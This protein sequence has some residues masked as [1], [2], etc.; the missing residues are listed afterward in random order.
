MRRHNR[1]MKKIHQKKPHRISASIWQKSARP[2]ITLVKFKKR[3][4]ALGKTAGWTNCPEC[5]GRLNL[6]LVDP[7]NR[8]RMWCST[9][10]CTELM[11]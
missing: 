11:E 10:G 4:L 5:G 8:A 3:L 1:A 9:P 7:R 6:R 2:L